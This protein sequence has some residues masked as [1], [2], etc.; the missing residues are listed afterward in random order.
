MTT[1]TYHPAKS[2][3]K[4]A[5]IAVPPMACA[6][7]VWAVREFLHREIPAEPATCNG[8]TAFGLGF[9]AGSAITAAACAAF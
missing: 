1:E 9:G 2:H 4:A 6:I 7:L 8:W 3:S 5:R